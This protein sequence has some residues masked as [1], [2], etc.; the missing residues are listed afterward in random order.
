LKALKLLRDR[1][2]L[3]NGRLDGDEFPKGIHRKGYRALGR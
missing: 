3:P 2:L 1:Y